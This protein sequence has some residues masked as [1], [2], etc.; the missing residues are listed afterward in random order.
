M[1]HS[2]LTSH[3]EVAAT[4]RL[5]ELGGYSLSWFPIKIRTKSLSHAISVTG[6]STYAFWNLYATFNKCDVRT[7]WFQ[8][9]KNSRKAIWKFDHVTCLNAFKFSTCLLV[10]Q[11]CRTAIDYVKCF[12]ANFVFTWKQIRSPHT[13]CI[14]V[15]Q[16]TLRINT[17]YYL[18]NIN[19]CLLIKAHFAYCDLSF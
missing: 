8:D 14:Y 6:N 9:L 7:T 19:N 17:Y 1:S 15:V 11:N 4:V 16:I 12:T 2:D 10:C 5:T 13:G 3:T 18:N